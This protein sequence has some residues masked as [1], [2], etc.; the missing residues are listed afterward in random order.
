MKTKSNL[1]KTT[2]MSMQT[3]I[4]ACT[5]KEALGRFMNPNFCAKFYGYLLEVTDDIVGI[6]MN[7]DR[8]YEKEQGALIETFE[9]FF[10]NIFEVKFDSDKPHYE[11][12]SSICSDTE[13]VQGYLADNAEYNLDALSAEFFEVN[14]FESLLKDTRNTLAVFALMFLLEYFKN[15]EYVWLSS[16]AEDFITANS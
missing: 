4:A 6:A 7:P 5:S 9:A 13:I 1:K 16:I 14:S 10:D 12:A 2:A 11:Y 8:G 3:I 15:S